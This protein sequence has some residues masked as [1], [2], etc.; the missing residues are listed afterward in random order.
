MEKP[1]GEMS[2]VEPPLPSPL[3]ELAPSQMFND[4][5]TPAAYRVITHYIAVHC[6]ALLYTA[7]HQTALH[8]TALYYTA[9]HRGAIHSSCAVQ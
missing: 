9:M 1:K 8:Y 6:T 2:I 5:H 3:A 4:L 7:M